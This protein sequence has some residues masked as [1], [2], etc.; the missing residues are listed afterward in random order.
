MRSI[1]V[2]VRIANAAACLA[3]AYGAVVERA[4][5]C[6][7][8]R[9]TVYDQGREVLA[10]VA[11]F[12]RRGREGDRDDLKT[13][14][15]RLRDENA[16]LW[17]WVDRAVEFDRD[18]QTRFA[19]LATAM[20]LSVGQVRELLVL[21]LG[22]AAAP[23]RSVVGRW[24]AAAGLAAG[25]VL[26]RLDALGRELVATACLDE[27]FFHGRPV[28][29]GVEP[30]SMTWFLGRKADSL[31]GETWAAALRDLPKLE[32]V[33]ADAGRALQSGIEQARRERTAADGPALD[34]TLDVFHTKYQAN[35]ALKIAWNRA[36]RDFD[37]YEVAR[38]GL[39]RARRQ[40]KPAHAE[41]AK[42]AAAW[43]AVETSFADHEAME[44]AWRAI[45]SALEFFRPDDGLN[46]RAWAEARVAEHLPALRGRA[47]RPVVNHLRDPSSFTFLDR[48]HAELEALPIAPELRSALLELQR[49][50]RR[51][52]R[53]GNARV[54]HLKQMVTCAGLDADWPRWH[55]EVARIIQATTRASSVVECM[56]SV[57][58]MHQS[59]HRTVTQ[60]MLDLKRLYWNTRRFQGGQRRGRSPYERLGLTLPDHD[61]WGLLKEELEAALVDAKHE[62][63]RKARARLVAKIAA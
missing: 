22:A 51:G 10:A 55:R 60:G 15:D 16:A 29:V 24:T 45:A 46:D 37:A 31:R 18:K 53:D 27:I 5:L 3:G 32:H 8:S 42:A 1:P 62:A 59:R 4:R 61:F 9:Q 19:A 54:E 39:D 58:R 44:S 12:D 7:C 34:S 2:V 49:T 17:A 35:K 20:G 52:R 41:G 23:S 36:R 56:N 11:A 21:I 43:R 40:G 63:A 30:A 33:V 38:E 13:E 28:L 48:M 6:G 25:R 14:L 26:A 47:W 57:L 50:R